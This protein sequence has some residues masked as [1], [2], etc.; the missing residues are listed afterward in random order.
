[1]LIV[2]FRVGDATRYGSLEGTTV[3]EYAGTP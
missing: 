1:M 3:V 2:R